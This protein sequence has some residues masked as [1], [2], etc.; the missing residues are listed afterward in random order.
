MIKSTKRIFSIFFAVII[1][2]SSSIM[3]SA[4]GQKVY[5]NANLL[6]SEELSDIQNL[7]QNTSKEINMDIVIV[8]TN[9]DEGKAPMEYA[10]DFYDYN[11]FGVGEYKDGILLYV[12]MTTRDM[13]IS[14]SGNLRK[15][16]DDRN[17]VLLKDEV[18]PYLS[19]GD[20][21]KAFKTFINKTESFVNA[22]VP[23]EPLVYDPGTDSNINNPDYFNAKP[24]LIGLCCG[25]VVA[26]ISIIVV[27]YRYKFHSVPSAR[28]YVDNKD[29]Y[30]REKNDIF[31]RE[32]TTSVKIE[33]NS[34]SGGGFSGGSSSHTS[35]SGSSHGGCGGKF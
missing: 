28:A 24:L 12:N 13:W 23:N 18:T 33:S 14:T 6:S 35:S 19:D 32:Y 7:A 17:Q 26:I 34:G 16:V 5:D 9:D 22:G 8:T 27:C 2:F 31:L 11:G 10:D 3:V 30:F 25:V 29:T 21:Y 15:Y 20:Y 1:L 4:V